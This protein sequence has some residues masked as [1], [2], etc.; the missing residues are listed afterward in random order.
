MIFVQI[1]KQTVA[2]AAALIL[3]TRPQKQKQPPL[4]FEQTP[5]VEPQIQYVREKTNFVS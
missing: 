5:A 4:M 3:K 2:E 1:E